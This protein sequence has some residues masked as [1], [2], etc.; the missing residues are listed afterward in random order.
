MVKP[1]QLR[2]AGILI[3]AILIISITAAWALLHFGYKITEE[4]HNKIVEALELK[5]KQDFQQ[6]EAL[7][8]SSEEQTEEQVE[9]PTE[10]PKEE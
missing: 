2:I 7:E 5:H 1:E 3:V 10:E 8:A 4:E 6:A 9:E